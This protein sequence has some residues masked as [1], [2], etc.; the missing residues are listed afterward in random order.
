MGLGRANHTLTPFY[1][2][3][4]TGRQ[5]WR[6]AQAI[7]AIYLWGVHADPLV[8]RGEID[9]VATAVELP[10]EYGVPSGVGCHDLNVVKACEKAGLKADFY[11]KTYHRH[12]YPTAPKNPVTEPYNEF[13][14]YWCASPAE[15]AEFMRGVEKPWIAFKTM[16]AGA[17]PPTQ[18]FRH[19]VEAGADFILA[20][21]FDSIAHYGTTLR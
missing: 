21:M 12:N 1:P 3:P 15:T 2:L 9:L 19:A 18:A 14:G 8:A 5:G 4:S 16:A 7:E 11:I 10:K 6:V 20:G 17:I 13:P